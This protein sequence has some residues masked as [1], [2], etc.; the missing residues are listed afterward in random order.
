MSARPEVSWNNP[1]YI[2]KHRFYELKHLCLQYP[3][4]QKQY[5]ALSGIVRPGL[6]EKVDMIGW[7]GDITGETALL[8]LFYK[9]RMKM[10]KQVAHQTD[11]VIG[12]YIFEAV[13]RDLSYDKLNAKKRIPCCKD[14][15]Y[16]KYREFFWNLSQVRK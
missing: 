13:I 14:I 7:T 6:N 10:I 16:E 15:Y 12:E 2:S 3:E 5:S 1:N 9:D 4:W 11:P 8:G